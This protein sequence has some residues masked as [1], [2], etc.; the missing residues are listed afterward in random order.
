V[1]HPHAG[2]YAGQAGVGARFVGRVGMSGAAARAALGRETRLVYACAMI[3]TDRLSLRRWRDEDIVPFAALNADQTAMRFMPGVMTAEETRALIARFEE[4]HRANGFGVWAV[5]APGVAP[6]VGFVG[7][8]QVA[9]EAPFTPAV[10]IGWRLAPAYWGKGYA[11]EAALAVLRFGF[12]ELNLDQIVSFTV[13]ANK[14]SWSVMERLGMM[15]NPSEDF[16]HPRLPVGHA[17]RRHVLYRMTR[18]AWERRH[19]AGTL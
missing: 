5:E 7:L 6:F 11:T 16:D 17:L 4:H 15:R 8:Q 18:D 14:P 2:D 13:P 3:T 12:E 19:I 10:E 9:F 1:E